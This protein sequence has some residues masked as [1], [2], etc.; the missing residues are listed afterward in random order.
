[1]MLQAGLVLEG[2]G[3]RGVYTA[4]VLDFF[5]DKELDFARVY[6][7]SAGACNAL[8]YLSRD[9]GAYVQITKQFCNDPRYCGMRSLLT[10]G[11]LF[12][13]DF[14]FYEIPEKHVPYSYDT[15]H[16]SPMKLYVGATDC[17]TGRCSWFTQADGYDL[18]GCSIA[19]SSMPLVSPMQQLRDPESG[20]LRR[21]LDGGI[22]DSI[23]VERAAQ[24]GLPLVVVLTR[25]EGYQKKKNP[26]LPMMR[27]KYRRYPRLVE[28]MEHRHEVY[29]AS[30]A[31]CREMEQAGQAVIIRPTEPMEIGRVEH[32]TEKL[33]KA[34]EN[35]YADAQ[36]AYE[37]ILSLCAPEQE[38]A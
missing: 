2:G 27:V 25:N 28:A 26:M 34:Y 38:Q 23:P 7:I 9:R 4:G 14:A 8:R 30:L 19:S 6:G 13:W 12:N 36:A 22:A 20:Q 15:F 32:D 11:S 3:M 5:L 18:I 21:Y 1:M 35:G 16:N 10:T 24:D 29:N 17:T 37:R 31:R 33:Q